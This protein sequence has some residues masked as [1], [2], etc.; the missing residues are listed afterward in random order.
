MKNFLKTIAVL[1]IAA[2]V[3]FSAELSITTA[4]AVGMVCLLPLVAVVEA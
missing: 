4:L 3:G 1:V 2:L